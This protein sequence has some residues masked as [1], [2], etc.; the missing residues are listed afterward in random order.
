[1]LFSVSLVVVRLAFPLYFVNT[2]IG[3]ISNAET[4]AAHVLSQLK[5]L[6][7]YFVPVLLSS[8]FLVLIED[9]TS[10]RRPGFKFAVKDWNGPLMSTSTDYLLYASLCALLAFLLVL[11]PH[12]GSYLNYA[13][14]LVLPLFFSWFFLKFDPSRKWGFL[15]AAAV[16]FNLFF[17]GTNVL[18]ASLLESRTAK[19]WDR[20][21]SYIRSSSNILNSPVITSG[22]IRFGLTPLDSG[23][24]S[25]FYSVK[26]YPDSPLLGPR[27]HAFRADG[28][29]YIKF[30]DNSIEKQKFD[31]VVTTMEKSTFYHARFL[32]EFYVPVDRLTV[33][34]PHTDQHWTL[35]IW[36]PLAQ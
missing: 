9:D 25:Y 29:N 15:I 34:M 16:I 36:K 12:I 35:L 32:E 19:E 10:R 27:Y 13:Y 3:N 30:I 26:P 24:T 33:D 5:Q 14:Q 31:L 2:I 7:F 6:L 21:Y 20:L 17:W 1:M 18:S 23:Q 11:G 28:F 4:S 8:L 22:V